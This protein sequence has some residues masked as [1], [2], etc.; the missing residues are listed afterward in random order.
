M[1]ARVYYRRRQPTIR[2]PSRAPLTQP[3]RQ[4][5]PRT[6]TSPTPGQRAE[7]VCFTGHRRLSPE[8][9][10]LL[11]HRLNALLE[12]LFR[13]G[14]RRFICG[15][16]LGFDTLAAECVLRLQASHPEVRLVMA[17]PCGNQA[18]RWSS[19][20]SRRYERILYAADETHVLAPTYYDGCMMVRNRYMVDR[21]ALCVCYLCHMKGGTV[22]TVAYALREK[23]P[24]LNVAMEGACAAFLRESGVT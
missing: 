1:S 9:S 4:D 5:P 17:L 14:Y 24:V 10:A 12:A 11:S 16:A 8:E 2:Q 19:G 13:R 21:A 6:A 20:D 7:T 22:S 23:V 18:Q 15:G 3:L